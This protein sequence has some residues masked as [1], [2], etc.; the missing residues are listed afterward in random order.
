MPRY[1]PPSISPPPSPPDG[2]WG[3]QGSPNYSYNDNYPSPRQWAVGREPTPEGSPPVVGFEIVHHA[4]ADRTAEEQQEFLAQNYPD[5]EEQLRQ[6]EEGPGPQYEAHLGIAFEVHNAF[7]NIKENYEKIIQEMGGRIYLD[8]LTTI[9]PD[10]LVKGLDLFFAEIIAKRDNTPL[11]EGEEYKKLKKILIRLLLAKNEVLNGHFLNEIFTWFQFVMRQPESFQFQYAT[12]F[13]ED[14][15]SAYSDEMSCVK[16]IRERLL[17][18][19]ADACILHC[20]EFK[21]KHKRKTKKATKKHKANQKTAK[22]LAKVATL[23]GGSP[24]K[25]RKCDNPLYRRLIRLF[26][27]EVPDMNELTKEWSVIFTKETPMTPAQL[28]QDFIDFMDRK[29]KLY[30][31]DNFAAIQKRAVELEQAGIFENK[32]F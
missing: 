6:Q 3:N 32:E 21:K 31:I 23:G 7:E 29:Y 1:T 10:E 22:K 25:F 27:K 24:S 30:N 4:F 17:L 15:I 18:S 11:R 5:Y 28:K 19:I 26:K 8:I 20:F 9:G 2:W 12:Y 16:G 14:T 13:I